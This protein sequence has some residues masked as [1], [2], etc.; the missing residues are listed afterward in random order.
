MPDPKEQMTDDE[1]RQLLEVALI[2]YRP[3]D[4]KIRE[5]EADQEGND[6]NVC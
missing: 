1:M 5:P 2:I 3:L 6:E 4:P